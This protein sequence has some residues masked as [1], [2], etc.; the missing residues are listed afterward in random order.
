TAAQHSQVAS[1]P[2][3]PRFNELP[4]E[5]K[6]PPCHTLASRGKPENRGATTTPTG[7]ATGNSYPARVNALHPQTRVARKTAIFEAVWPWH[8]CCWI[9]SMHIVR[10]ITKCIRPAILPSGAGTILCCRHRPTTSMK[11]GES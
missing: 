1:S 3:G 2:P 11:H 4:C 8:A 9:H 6:Q 5:G 7:Y 10:H